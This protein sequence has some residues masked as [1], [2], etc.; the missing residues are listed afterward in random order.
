MKVVADVGKAR[1]VGELVKQNALTTV[2]KLSPETM[3]EQVRGWFIENGVSMTEYR[4]MLRELGI[5]R[6][7]ITKRHNLKHRVSI[8]Q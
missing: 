8:C 3:I 4:R 6:N 5:N 1:V 2:V 7:G